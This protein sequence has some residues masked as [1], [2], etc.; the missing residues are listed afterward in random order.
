MPHQISST[1]GPIR[2]LVSDEVIEIAA[3]MNFLLVGSK[4]MLQSYDLN[5]EELRV[6]KYLIFK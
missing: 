5:E 3:S 4:R 1:A 6:D 2:F